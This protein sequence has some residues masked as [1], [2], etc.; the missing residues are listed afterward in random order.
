MIIVF[1]PDVVVVQGWF[2]VGLIKKQGLLVES[3]FEDGFYALIGKT[4]D[5]ERTAAGILQSLR[6]V[7]FCQTHDTEAGPIALFG[8]R[9]AVHDTGHEHFRFWAIFPSPPDYP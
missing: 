6:A 7:V 3:I 5:D 1:S 9:P 2:R 4:F 8:M